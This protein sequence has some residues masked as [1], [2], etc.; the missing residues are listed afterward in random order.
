[1]R[2]AYSNDKLYP[3][4]WKMFIEHA[5]NIIGCED[6]HLGKYRIPHPTKEEC[7]YSDDIGMLFMMYKD[8]FYRPDFRS[9]SVY[10]KIQYIVQ[11]LNH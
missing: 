2:K 6:E 1:M 3:E 8:A 11:H 10:G 5:R 7:M 9:P 4:A